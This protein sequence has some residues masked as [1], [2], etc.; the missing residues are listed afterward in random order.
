MCLRKVWHNALNLSLHEYEH[1]E[2][3]VL[4]NKEALYATDLKACLELLELLQRE[5]DNDESDNVKKSKSEKMRSAGRIQ[6]QLLCFP[7]SEFIKIFILK[8]T[9]PN[10]DSWA[11]FFFTAL[12]LHRELPPLSSQLVFQC[13]SPLQHELLPSKLHCSFLFFF[14]SMSILHTS[15]KG[16]FSR[17]F[18]PAVVFK[19]S[20]R[21]NYYKNKNKSKKKK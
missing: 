20:L 3:T 7:S 6:K 10:L 4:Y 13:R 17:V 11:F 15:H 21:I 14:N 8:Q 9:F 19:V 2:C 1:C 18:K 12:L 16:D 5:A